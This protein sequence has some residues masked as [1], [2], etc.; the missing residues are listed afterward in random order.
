M[1]D[2]FFYRAPE[3]IEKQEQAE[4]EAN[5]L[6]AVKTDGQ[7]APEWAPDAPT[8]PTDDADWTGDVPAKTQEF[9]KAAD[10]WDK[11]A[12]AAGGAAEGWTGKLLYIEAWHT[13][14]GYGS[15]VASI[16]G[17]VKQLFLNTTVYLSDNVSF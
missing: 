8:I 4:K 15:N 9:Q 17:S 16:L 5:E 14:L 12:A 6:Q 2:L 1:P 13:F 7:A 10:D 11:P 3:D